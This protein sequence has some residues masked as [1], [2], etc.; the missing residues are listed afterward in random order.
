MI[1]GD[2]VASQLSQLSKED[3]LNPSFDTKRILPFNSKVLTILLLLYTC[4]FSERSSH[5]KKQSYVDH[6]NNT[7]FYFRFL[8]HNI[9]ITIT[10]P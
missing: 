5:D 10:L 4:V 2:M 3:A 7:Y 8:L 1:N 6:S 9:S